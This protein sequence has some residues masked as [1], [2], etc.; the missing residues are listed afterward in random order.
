MKLKNLFGM[1]A[2]AALVLSGCSSDEVVENFSPENVI[3]FGTYVGRDAQSRVAETTTTT[4]Q[5]SE[6]GFGVF[7]TY[8]QNLTTGTTPNFMNNQQVK[9]DANSTNEVTKWTYSPIKYWPNN[10]NAEVDF[11]AYA[12]YN[13][14]NNK[15]T[16][17]TFKIHDGKDYVATEK[18]TEGKQAV[19]DK[20]VF[21]FNHVMSRIGFKVEAVLDEIE[22]TT[23]QNGKPSD[24]EADE[25]TDST[26][27]NDF[28]KDKQGNAITT[29]VVTEVSLD[30]AFVKDG[31]MTWGTVTSDDGTTSERWILTETEDSKLTENHKLTVNDNNINTFKTIDEVECAKAVG[32]EGDEGY[33]E[34]ETVK[35]QKATISSAQ[36]NKD[37]AY[38]MVVPQTAT[39]MT[40]TVKY[41]VITKDDKL[42]TG[43]S[44]VNNTVTSDKFTFL[45]ERNH[46]YNFVLHLGMTSVK[47]DAEVKNSWEESDVI[48]NVPLNET[49]VEKK[50]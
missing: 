7:A 16:V 30:Y 44:C 25:G 37:D 33:K 26:P 39:D 48:V 45:F 23:D 11:W 31:T 42:A 19:N 22:H 50:N 24:E 9:Y 49:T 4:L 8:N 28:E 21:E 32:N 3:E 47:F 46:A 6:E 27:D 17:P 43:Y 41:S 20:V 2:M 12:P 10:A 18:K 36:L 1:A 29:I 15:A 38:F 13:D 5:A 14:E 34:A 35:G 40:I